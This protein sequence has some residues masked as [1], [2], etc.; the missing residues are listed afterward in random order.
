[1]HT[2]QF[3][4]HPVAFSLDVHGTGT[5]SK[6]RHYCSLTLS[7]ITDHH[8]LTVLPSTPEAWTTLSG[9]VGAWPRPPW[10]SRPPSLL[11]QP[12]ASS[13]IPLKVIPP[14]S[15]Q[16]IFCNINLTDMWQNP[17]PGMGPSNSLPETATV[18]AVY[19]PS[20]KHSLKDRPLAS[21]PT[22]C[23]LYP[24]TPGHYQQ[25]PATVRRLPSGLCQCLSSGC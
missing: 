3:S 17:P 18:P 11:G 9:D 16:S 12:P 24:P 22:Q 1:M 15:S 6:Q 5:T 19:A 23:R 2:A 25:S 13:L 4:T 7:V 20:L 10:F 14:H 21:W 8:L